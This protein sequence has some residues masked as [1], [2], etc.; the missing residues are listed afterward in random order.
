MIAL[1]LSG[2][3]GDWCRPKFIL[4][5]NSDL[6]VCAFVKR[7]T[8]QLLFNFSMSGPVNR[9]QTL[10][11]TLIAFDCIAQRSYQ[12]S[13]GQ[14]TWPRWRMGFC[15]RVCK[16]KAGI[17]WVVVVSDKLLFCTD[18]HLTDDGKLVHPISIDCRNFAGLWQNFCTCLH[19]FI[20]TP[21]TIKAC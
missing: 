5:S 12:N 1:G 19:W 13:A 14:L 7:P 21:Y 3:G 9:T 8:A 15:W 2:G 18:R 11:L 20:R 6:I 17:V 10:H 4:E 16:S